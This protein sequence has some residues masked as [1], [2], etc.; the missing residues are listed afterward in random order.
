VDISGMRISKLTLT[1]TNMTKGVTINNCTTGLLMSGGGRTGQSVGSVTFIDST[2]RN[3]QVAFVTAHDSTSSPPTGGSLI[4]E[5]VSLINVPVAVQ[6]PTGTV[7][8][9]GT[10]IIAGWGQGHKYIPTGPTNF[11]A[12]TTPFPRPASLLAQG[13]F[14]AR[15]KPQYELLPVLSFVSVRTGGAKGDGITDDTKILN[16]ILASAA[17]S[18]L[19]IFFDAGTYKVTSTIF[20]PVGS[21]IVGESFSVIMG[22]G[23]FFSNIKSP[24]PVVSVG[25]AGQTGVVEWSDMIVS[26]QGA[27]AGAILIQWNLASSATSPSGMWDVHTRIGGFAGSDLQLAQCPTTPTVPGAIN[28]RCIAAFM[29]MY[30]APAASGLYLE[31]NWFWTADHDID[32][33][34]LRQITIYSGRGFYSA[35]SVG[36][37]WMWGTSVEHHSLYQYQFVNTRNV[38]AGQIQTETAYWQP[39]PNASAVFPVQTQYN[40]PNFAT[41]CV[42]VSGNCASGWGLRVVTSQNILIYGAGLYS[43]FNN[44]STCKNSPLSSQHMNIANETSLL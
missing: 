36:T 40:D 14:Y 21:R 2:I 20:I 33:P 30:V 41:S 38:Y 16:Q 39:N 22:A 26:T 11:M 13:K 15:S 25:L 31:N 8:P 3:T 37:I 32:D 5:N 34:S 19:V 12:S 17:G 44:Y 27:T 29:S 43:F 1:P 9:G 18:N 28:Q 6:G 24:Q 10:L 42:G 23:P 4:L 35:S 7:L